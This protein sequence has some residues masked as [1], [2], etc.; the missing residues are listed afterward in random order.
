MADLKGKV[1]LVS[2]AARGIGATI[3]QTMV[4][5]GGKV[6]IGDLLDGEGQALAEEIGPSATYV[7]L[8]VTSPD[9][10][11]APSQRRSTGTAS[12][13]CSVHNAGIAGAAPIEQY[14]RGD[15]EKIVAA[16][17]TGVFTASRPSFLR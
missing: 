11:T 8:D 17:L 6:V 4:D 3:A 5:H 7:H 2:G 10:W 13:T 12:S 15:W 14:S 9:E 16:N 1:A